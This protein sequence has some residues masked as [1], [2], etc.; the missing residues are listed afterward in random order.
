MKAG[1]DD[2]GISDSAYMRL[3]LR[4]IQGTHPAELHRRASELPHARGHTRTGIASYERIAQILEVLPD[5]EP[6]MTRSVLQDRL[7]LTGA[8][9]CGLLNILLREGTIARAGRGKKSDPYT[10]WRVVVG[11]DAEGDGD[12]VTELPPTTNAA[13]S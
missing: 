11:Q 9:A 2:A 8:R 3:A 13:R 5:R 6:G 7:G 1:A 4:D 12:S 10:Y